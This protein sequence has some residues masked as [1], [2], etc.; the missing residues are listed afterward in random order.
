MASPPPIVIVVATQLL[1]TISDFLARANLKDMPFSVS[2]LW[3]RWFVAYMVIRQV[4]T[5]GQLY[6]LANIELGRS[7]G[8]FALTSLLLANAVGVFFLHDSLS[9]RQYLGVTVGAL[10]FLLLALPDGPGS[11]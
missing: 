11:E 8:L 10:G 5:L 4:A 2:I 6:A 1:F 3:T 7:A 9:A